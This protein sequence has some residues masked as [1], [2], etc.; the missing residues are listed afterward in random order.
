M[1]IASRGEHFGYYSGELFQEN[2]TVIEYDYRFMDS[3]FVII[4]YRN[5]SK[6]QSLL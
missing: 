4:V 3:L 2:R 5:I 1:I 6:L